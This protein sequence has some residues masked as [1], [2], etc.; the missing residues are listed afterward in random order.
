[1]RSI[2]HFQHTKCAT[3]SKTLYCFEVS[4]FP[5]LSCIQVSKVN[6]FHMIISYWKTMI[7]FSKLPE[8]PEIITVQRLCRVELVQIIFILWMDSSEPKWGKGTDHEHSPLSIPKHPFWRVLRTIYMMIFVTSERKTH[9]FLTLIHA[10]G[11]IL[12]PCLVLCILVV[13]ALVHNQLFVASVKNYVLFQK[14]FSF[15]LLTV[16]LSYNLADLSILWQHWQLM[17][18]H[19]W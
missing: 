13:S 12:L 8:F 6:F 5:F 11:V 3:T 17:K 14:W 10:T 2:V 15:L 9:H 7:F 18:L 4:F 1:M 16:T 19:H